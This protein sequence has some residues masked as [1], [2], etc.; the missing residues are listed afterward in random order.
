MF[1]GG[2]KMPAIKIENAGKLNSWL[3]T[4]AKL[5]KAWG[6]TSVGVDIGICSLCK[7]D[8]V[9]KL[10]TVVWLFLKKQESMFHAERTLLKRLL[11][12]IFETM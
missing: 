12:L 1:I 9:S 6:C 8:H 3:L 4:Q 5:I 2:A 10:T 7:S 11:I